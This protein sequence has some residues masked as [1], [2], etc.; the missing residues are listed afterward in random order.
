MLA[1][2]MG[3]EGRT[4]SAPMGFLVYRPKELVLLAHAGVRSQ[5]ALL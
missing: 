1:L 5:K 4:W 3:G 2:P